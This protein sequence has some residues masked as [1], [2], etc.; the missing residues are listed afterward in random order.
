MQF[1]SLTEQLLS[2]LNGYMTSFGLNGGCLEW[3]NSRIY[4][5]N[6]MKILKN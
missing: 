4:V 5:L 3:H 2:Y 1:F 6:H